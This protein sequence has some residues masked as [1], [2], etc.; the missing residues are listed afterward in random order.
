MTTAEHQVALDDVKLQAFVGQAVTELGATLGAALVVIGDRLGLYKAMAGAGPLS[1]KEVATRTDT[2]ERYVREW[3]NAQAAGGYVSYDAR[4][5]RYT[6]PP[7][8]AF[9]LVDDQ[10]PVFLPGAFQGVVSAVR[11]A[12]RAAEAFRTGAEGVECQEH[13][14]DLFGRAERFL[15]PGYSANLIRSWIPALDGVEGKL[16]RGARVADI[17]CGD[18]ASTI[19]MAQAY[20]ASTFVGFDDRARSIE[21]ARVRAVQA[22]V[23]DRARF[24][25]AGAKEY[26]GSGYDLVTFFD[27]LHDVGDPVGVAR[28]VRASLDLD[29]TWLIVEPFAADRVEDNLNPVGRVYYGASTLMCAPARLARD[30]ELALGAQAGQARLRAVTTLAGFTRFRRAAETRFNEVLEARP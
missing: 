22:G 7:E 20:P 25:V 16:R 2:E 29:G 17:G 18:G 23:Q 6:L 26:A 14:P 5:G 19:L 10:S 9:A 8:Q 21:Q 12:H 3:L 11:N 24:E 15:G 27:C 1:P 4:T 13:S 28:H 30:V